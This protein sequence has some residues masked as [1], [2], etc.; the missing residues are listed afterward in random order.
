MSYVTCSMQHAPRRR[1][2]SSQRTAPHREAAPAPGS[3]PLAGELPALTVVPTT[4][5][6]QVYQTL[7]RGIATGEIA[8]GTRLVA[9]QL[10]DRWGI[11]RTPVNEALH[12]LENEGLITRLAT[13]VCEVVG[14]SDE[15]IDELYTVR[16]MLEGLCAQRAALRATDETLAELD[17]IMQE[18][19]E[20]T[21][22]KDWATVDVLGKEFHLA[23]QAASGLHQ[24]PAM[25]RSL[26][27]LIDRYRARTIARPGRPPRAFEE[28]TAIVAAIRDRDAVRAEAAMREH[29]LSAWRS[30]KGGRR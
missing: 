17:R 27:G 7:R 20:A 22:R 13:G 5:R 9:S 2:G 30:A 16:A 24:V 29:I 26:E 12:L 4:L 21:A 25:L 1:M 3:S 15:R 8:S 6:E 11:S 19:A 28:H 10:A 18:I 14:L 23:I